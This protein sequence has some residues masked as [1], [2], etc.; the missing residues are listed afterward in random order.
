MGRRRELKE[1]REALSSAPLLTITGPAGVGKTRLALRLGGDLRRAFPDGVVL[2]ALDDL[3]DPA[4]LTETVAGSL[5]LHDG[6]TRWLMGALSDFLAEKRLLLILDNCEHVLDAAAILADALMRGCPGV[7]ILATSREPLGIGG[8][9]AMPLAPLSVPPPAANR[10]A[11]ALLSFEA[12]DLFVDRA[13]AASPGF[14]LT[15]D[16]GETVAALCTRLDGIPLAIELAAVRLR[17]LTVEQILRQ[18]DDRFRLLTTG[19]RVASPRQQTLRAAIDWSFELLSEPERVSWRRLAVFEGG[20]GLGSAEEVC[21]DDVLPRDRILDLVAGLVDRSIVAR[22]ETGDETRYRML[23]TRYRMLETIRAFGLEQLRASGEEPAIRRRHRDWCLSFAREVREKSWGPDQEGWWQRAS[24]ELP[25][26]RV[27]LRYCAS[28]PGEVAT[29]LAIASDIFYW[30]LDVREGRRWLDELLALDDAPTPE[31][32]LA[33]ASNAHMAFHR[34]DVAAGERAGTAARAL[35]EDLDDDRLRCVAGWVLGQGA[36]LQG[37]LDEA[38]HL[39]DA[40]RAPAERL[41]DRR[42]LAMVLN[43]LGAVLAA[44]GDGD[45]AIELCRMSASISDEIGDRYFR[46]AADFT[47]G[48]ERW[49]RGELDAAAELVASCIRLHRRSGDPFQLAMALEGFAWIATTGAREERAAHLMG[50]ADRLFTES[51]TMIFPPW[52][53]AHDACESACRDRLGRAAFERSFAAGRAA[54]TDE[55]VAFALGETP[56]APTSAAPGRSVSELTP[57][58]REIAVLVAE[59]LSNRDVA[60]RLVISPRTAETHVEHIL[61]KLGFTSRAQIAAWV[62]EEESSPGSALA[63]TSG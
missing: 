8:E 50:G 55:V 53:G 46:S 1:L 44:G 45:G 37:R 27:A 16:N 57:R 24:T 61:T 28:D 35:A 26:L 59:G 10:P 48:V 36:L 34:M 17:A 49:K 32:A 38:A 39:L 11:E 23:E 43:T 4:V 19:S 5:G 47:V 33:L 21:A 22:E 31:R 58:E 30:G 18:M 15:G 3:R 41:D 60:S 6:S 12:V 20:F 25:N 29:G 7:R 51:G 54:N 62:V 52:D 63:D 56:T 9:V 13:R 40:A 14:E 42:Y 2:V